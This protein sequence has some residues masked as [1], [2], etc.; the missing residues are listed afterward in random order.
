MLNIPKSK[1]LYQIRS[2]IF[3]MTP[4][5]YSWWSMMPR[6]NFSYKFEDTI[7]FRKKNSGHNNNTLNLELKNPN[8]FLHNLLLL[9]SNTQAIW[10]IVIII[11]TFYGQV[12]KDILYA[13]DPYHYVLWTFKKKNSSFRTSQSF[14]HPLK[15]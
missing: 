8:G 5:V 9:S 12:K 15:L 3:K 14:A 2:N 4:K 7:N 1:Q 13:K 11:F 6:D 10:K